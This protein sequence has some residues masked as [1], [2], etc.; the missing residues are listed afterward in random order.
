MGGLSEMADPSGFIQKQMRTKEFLECLDEMR[1]LQ[2]EI[3]LDESFERLVNNQLMV[4][5]HTPDGDMYE[6]MIILMKCYRETP[7]EIHTLRG[8]VEWL[9]GLPKGEPE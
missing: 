9:E 2:D 6:N 1:G 3:S 8:F 5:P 7:E 4:R